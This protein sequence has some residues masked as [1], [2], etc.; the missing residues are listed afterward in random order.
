MKN[1]GLKICYILFIPYLLLL[2]FI[3][4]VNIF[5]NKN[6][7]NVAYAV[8]N[9][10][11]F[12]AHVSMKSIMLN[13]NY[14]TF[15]KFFI[16]ITSEFKTKQKIIINKICE[17]H[18]NCNISYLEM[19][20]EFN[21]LNTK[22]W[23]KAIFY[24]LKLPILLDKE[25]KILYF[26]CDTLIYKDLKNIYNYN[27][28]NKYYI[29]MP[30]H[31]H[32]YLK[33]FNVKFNVFI[34]SGVLLI[35]LEKLRKDNIF[36][37]IKHFLIKYNNEINFPDQDSINLVCHKKNGYFPPKYVTWG[38]CNINLIDSYIKSLNIRP[39]KKEIIKSYKDPY[40]YHLMGYRNKPW[41]GI[42]NKKGY[43]CFDQITRFYEYARKSS[44]YYE[45]LEKFKVIKKNLN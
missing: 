42:T 31:I 26:D 28:E 4:N 25:K 39:N 37:K 20:N 10:Y 21:H 12:I 41:N 44:Y 36:K 32:R 23:S 17:E 7:I 43:I 22:F 13:Q 30:E 40:I 38:F 18:K 45:I 8:D 34:N 6:I 27:I 24:R 35:N 2:S 16:L 1:L 29:G 5:H 33:K 15:I 11:Y 3:K 19:G 9:N 14:N